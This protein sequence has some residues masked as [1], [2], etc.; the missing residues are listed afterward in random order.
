MPPK[1]GKL[2]TFK[3]PMMD[4]KQCPVSWEVLRP[5]IAYIDIEDPEVREREGF[6][7]RRGIV[8]RV[9]IPSGVVPN[10]FDP[11]LSD[12]GRSVEFTCYLERSRYYP[13]YTLEPN[14]QRNK[15]VSVGVQ[16][17]MQDQWTFISKKNEAGEVRDYRKYTIML[18]ERCEK[19]FRNPYQNWMKAKIGVKGSRF[20]VEKIRSMFYYCFFFT[21]ASKDFT[22]A[23]EAV[24]SLL[25]VDESFNDN[26]M[27]A[28][29][30]ARTNYYNEKHNNHHGYRS[31]SPR[32]RSSSRHRSS[33]KRRSSRRHRSKSR[34]RSRRRSRRRSYSDE[35]ENLANTLKD[36]SLCADDSSI[37]TDM[38][39][40]RKTRS[41][42]EQ[43]RDYNN[44]ETASRCRSR[45][46]GK[47]RKF[48]NIVCNEIDSLKTE[49]LKKREQEVDQALRDVE[50][51]EMQRI[52]KKLLNPPQEVTSINNGQEFLPP[53]PLVSV[54]EPSDTPYDP[55]QRSPV[56]E[57]FSSARSSESSRGSS[58]GSRSGRSGLRS[59]HVASE[60]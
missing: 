22:P 29:N 49:E 32:K 37:E 11:V 35:D 23:M 52:Q 2:S 36:M 9:D 30:M 31:P 24:D 27:N 46:K 16:K 51:M 43:S 55:R 39:P 18:P 6:L 7:S 60:Y 4:N 38:E 48:L 14:L 40:K 47:Q 33:G 53:P 44:V 5:T 20:F 28:T 10:S 8:L 42:D 17:A 58:R 3:E 1:Q 25:R 19:E 59:S 41:R 45:V 56:V 21:E 26:P 13:K 50:E 34:H 54:Q 12:D 15:A 57:D